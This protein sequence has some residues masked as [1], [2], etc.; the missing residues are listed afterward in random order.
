MFFHD[1]PGW[2]VALRIGLVL[3]LIGG[4]VFVTRAA[5]YKGVAAGAGN[6]GPGYMTFSG[7]DDMMEFHHDDG[8][9]ESG[10]MFFHHPGNTMPHSGYAGSMGHYSGHAGPMGQYSGYAGR[11][12]HHSGGGFGTGLFHFIF[13][14]LGFFLLVKLIFGFGGMGMY[15]YGPMGWGP[16]GRP[17]HGGHYRHHRCYCPQCS[18]ERDEE[19]TPEKGPASKPKKKSA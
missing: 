17:Y 18:S 5:F 10:D 13:G 12:G 15:R 4:M 7:D 11:M 9:M 3:L 6:M 14:I 8:H 16:G 1:K 2:G 19:G